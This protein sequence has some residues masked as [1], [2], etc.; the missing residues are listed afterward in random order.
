MLAIISYLH[1]YYHL[2]KMKV[3]EQYFHVVLF[4]F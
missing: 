4:R 1:E 2:L 3:S